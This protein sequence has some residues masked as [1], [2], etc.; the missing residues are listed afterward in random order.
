[1]VIDWKLLFHQLFALEIKK[2]FVLTRPDDEQE[3]AYDRLLA[4]FL[5]YSPRSFN[6]LVE[7]ACM[8]AS[9]KEAQQIRVEFYE[10]PL[11]RMLIRD[12]NF[13][14]NV[15]EEA[16]TCAP[17]AKFLSLIEDNQHRPISKEENF[18]ASNEGRNV[19]NTFAYDGT[20]NEQQV[21]L[22]MVPGYAA[23]TIAFSIFEEIVGDAN[24]FHGRPKERPLLREDGIDLEFE[25]HQTFYS[26]GRSDGFDI[27]H[28]AGT[29]LGNT[30]G[31]NQETTDL[32]A[33][34]I[35]DLP[36]Q[37]RDSKFIFLGYSKGA[38]IVLDVVHRHP[39]LQERILGYVTHA[40]VMQG[41][42]AA[43]LF[44][45][46]AESVLRDVPIREFV[47]RL[48]AED[49]ENLAQVVSPLFSQIDLSWLSVPRIRSVL[50][51][52]GYDIEAHD[53]QVERLLGGREVHELLDGA[54]DM[55]PQERVRW[56]LRYLNNDTFTSP[57]Y[58]F[59]LSALADIRDFIEPPQ[60]ADGGKTGPS[61]LAPTFRDDGEFDW[62]NF[63]LDALFLYLSSL[64]GFKNAPGGLY[65]TQVDLANTK[66]LHLDRRPLV[67]SL[68]PEEINAIWEDSEVRE[69]L[70]ANGI[71]N[72]QVLSET[73]RCDLVEAEARSNIDAIDLG[74]FRGHHW[75]LFRQA[76]RPPPEMSETH[77]QWNFP[78]KAYMRA[79]LQVLALRNLVDH[80]Q[81]E[82][83]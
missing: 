46:Q 28:P 48:R 66:T 57:T 22:I 10:H 14:T 30:T 11:S 18:F 27:L 50:E 36:E 78:R 60:L 80:C 44:L 52:L 31:H 21:A 40:G 19:S 74:E 53:R 82:P 33:K 63:S 61:L 4:A 6:D 67:A 15:D 81:G 75:S 35:A 8:A 34:W 13:E 64:S 5:H 12:I 65:D 17:I 16:R 45:E 83:L 9:A 41:T 55:A 42:H 77:A 72:K 56:T 59:N 1:M 62:E 20:G 7:A 23:H 79:L 25:D 32:I 26:R 68:L 43:R 3:A 37:Y 51:M 71:A 24:E 39:G 38:P 29:E 47:D 70:S 58:L 2:E 73:P 76:L 54:L 49:S 69:Y